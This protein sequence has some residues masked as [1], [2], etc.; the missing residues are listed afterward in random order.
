[1]AI[2]TAGCETVPAEYATALSSQ[3]PKWQTTQCQQMRA[4]AARYDADVPNTFP[5]HQ[6]VLLGPYGIGIAVAGMEHREKKRKEFVRE[7]HLQCS[8]QPVP[9]RLLETGQ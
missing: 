4:A 9:E 2:A 7:M 5:L 8:S 3:D 6:G 1:M